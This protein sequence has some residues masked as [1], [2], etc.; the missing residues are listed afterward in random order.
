MRFTTLTLAAALLL[1]A[2][3][4]SVRAQQGL[5]GHGGPVRALAPTPDG[6][7]AVSGG[8]DQS[9]IVWDLEAQ[10][11]RRILRVHEGSVNAV[12][13]LPDGRFLTAGEDGRVALWAQGS[14]RPAR[15]DKTHE[16]P[17]LA[18]A[19]DAA[20]GR[21]ATGGFDNSARIF[22]LEDGRALRVL[23]GHRGAVTA[24][25]F[26]EGGAIATTGYD[27]ALRLWSADPAQAPR[28]IEAGTPLN[29]LALL[30]SGELA[31]GRADGAVL[32][33][34]RDGAL[35][36]QVE[37]T[38][39]PIIAL[40]AAPDGARLAA[41]SPRG[42]VAILDVK[43][44]RVR[45]TLNGPGLPV[46]SL[47]YAPDGRVL[48]TGG[49]DRL[50]RRWDARTGEHIG[51]IA[52]QAPADELAAFAGDRGAEVYRAC[53]ICHTLQPGEDNRAGPTLHR[54]FG[55]KAGTAP[56]Y[57]YSD[58]FRKLDLV[59]TRDTVSRLFEIGPQAYTPGTKMP[60]QRVTDA[61]DRAALMDFLE[62]AT[63]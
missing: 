4:A 18:L 3:A 60:E 24:I 19:V 10:R 5:A 41:A 1:A 28:V 42:A 13:A 36:A 59:W 20:G 40:A 25:A 31:A 33:F 54:V 58:A 49:G 17:I 9:A 55:R 38:D 2:P 27:G 44:A 52:P 45:F 51:A 43:E 57:D 61:Q 22:A 63:R 48:L 23:E 37:A 29:A 7:G 35:R 50:V 46:W 6:R 15:L 16:A 47:A 32:I 8:F 14:D 56:G 62:R 30:P 12:A 21:Y 34:S 11:A 53:A 39:A 26:L